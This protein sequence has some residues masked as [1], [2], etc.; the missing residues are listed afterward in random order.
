MSTNST[1]VS[2]DPRK[3]IC[4]ASLPIARM[5][6]LRHNS[7][8]LIAAPSNFVCLSACIV[9]AP[10]SLPAKSISENY[11]RIKILNSD[12]VAYRPVHFLALHQNELKDSV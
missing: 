3:G 12:K 8:L 6:S 2:V 10:R 4:R 9:S 1:F 5:H 7:D 11:K